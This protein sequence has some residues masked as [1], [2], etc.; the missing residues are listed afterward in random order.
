MESD[1]IEKTEKIQIL[2]EMVIPGQ[3]PLTWSTPASIG[4]GPMAVLLTIAPIR[5]IERAVKIYP[6]CRPKEGVN[7]S[8]PKKETEMIV[9]GMDLSGPGNTADTAVTVFRKHGRELRLSTALN[10]AEDKDIAALAA[11]LDPEEDV[12][13]GIDA[14]LSYNPGG[15]DRPGDAGL[16]KTLCAAGMHPGSVMTP[17]M[18]RMVYLTLR[19]M[20]VARL[21]HQANDRIRIAE[22]HPGGTL[23][24]RGAALEDVK[25]FK[26][27]PDARH[28]LLEWL[29]SRGLKGV[30]GGGKRPDRVS[31]H[32]VA[33][34]GAALGAWKWFSGEPA[35][36]HPASPPFHPFDYTC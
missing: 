16:R 36:I 15:G 2:S 32:Y 30:A 18:T 11:S 9:I 24:L 1:Y 4:V 25:A 22:V 6:V 10:G 21:L 7:E 19:G 13:A 26:K 3:P 35:W 5:C 27:S 12:V 8:H 28:R 23:T 34:C 17:T 31:D 33:A 20:A 14:P 29:N